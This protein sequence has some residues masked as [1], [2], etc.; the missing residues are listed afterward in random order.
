MKPIISLFLCLS[1]AACATPSSNNGAAPDENLDQTSS[2][3]QIAPRLSPRTLERG[4]CGLFIWSADQDRRFTLFA[5]SQNDTA[6]WAGP[7]GERALRITEKSGQVF[8]GQYTVQS[9]VETQT[10]VSPSRLK[11]SLQN[12]EEILSGTRFKGGTLTQTTQEGLERIMPI[13]GI[14]TC[15]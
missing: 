15:R 5:Q 3:G 11:L 4:D 13:V 1:L 7:Q 12:I 10:S 2:S 14:A 9:F 8:D 6:I